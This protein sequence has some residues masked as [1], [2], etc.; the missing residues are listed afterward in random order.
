[1]RRHRLALALAGLTLLAA[2]MLAVLAVEATQ[3]VRGLTPA[4]PSTTLPPAPA[5]GVPAPALPLGP[6]REVP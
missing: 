2:G 6:I 1:M 3:A 5:G 4:V